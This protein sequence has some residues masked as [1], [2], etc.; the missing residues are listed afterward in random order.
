[1]INVAS[2]SAYLKA[3]TQVVASGLK[4]L[5]AAVPGHKETIVAKPGSPITSSSLVNALP[6]GPLKVVSGPNGMCFFIA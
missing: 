5:A 6:S 1:M 3:T 2:K 4:P